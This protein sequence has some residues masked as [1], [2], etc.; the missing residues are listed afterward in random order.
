M[1]S[2]VK[3][4]KPKETSMGQDALLVT[5]QGNTME[6]VVSPEAKQMAFD[7][8]KKHGVT[9]DLGISPE[10]SPVAIDAKTGKPPEGDRVRTIGNKENRQDLVYHNT[11]R[12]IKLL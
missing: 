6:E 2:V 7:E 5:L 3:V 8:H 1:L 12:L 11:Y 9:G 10:G 4:E